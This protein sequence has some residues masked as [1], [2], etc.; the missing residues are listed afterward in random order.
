MR[1]LMAILII[2]CILIA[3]PLFGDNTKI[4]NQARVKTRLTDLQLSD[5]IAIDLIAELNFAHYISIQDGDYRIVIFSEAKLFGQTFKL[6]VRFYGNMIYCF[7]I[8]FE[9]EMAHWVL[10]RK[11]IKKEII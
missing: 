3:M 8:Q 6:Q 5:Y 2:N 4:T 1:K 7:D 10:E 11:I 9:N